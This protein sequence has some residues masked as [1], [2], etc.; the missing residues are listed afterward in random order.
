EIYYKNIYE[1]HYFSIYK[2][3]KHN[4]YLKTFVDA[5]LEKWTNYPIKET[6]EIVGY[7]QNRSNKSLELSV[8]MLA[9]ILGGAIGAFITVLFGS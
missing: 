6:S 1:Q 5:S 2:T 9:A 4:I 7:F 3:G 8:V